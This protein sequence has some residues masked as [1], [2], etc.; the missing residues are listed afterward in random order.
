[1][2][3]PQREI[4]LTGGSRGIGAAIAERYRAAG[5]RIISPSRSELDLADPRGVEQYLQRHAPDADVLINNAAENRILPLP[6]LTLD[7]WERMVAINVTAPFLLTRHFVQRMAARRWGRVVNISSIYSQ[8]S[9]AGRSAYST[10]KAALNGFT[11]A[12]AIEY[13]SQG[14][15]VNAVGPGFIDTDLTRQN[16]T[17]AQIELL[18]QQ[19]PMQRLGSTAE[20]AELVYRLGS[21]HNTYITGQF[22]A[23]D[24][25]FT[26]Q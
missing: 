23:I 14:V 4:F 9:R 7:D 26:V 13:A 24:G 20:V 17:P 5:C 2:S 10:T 1:M 25:G 11:R 16:N 22:V 21:E 12:T 6:E 18:R 3:T 8:L 15:L 19:V